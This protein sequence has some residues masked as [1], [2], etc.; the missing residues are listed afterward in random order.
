MDNLKEPKHCSLLLNF[1]LETFKLNKH[2]D[3]L[4]V[5][6]INGYCFQG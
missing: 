2:I 6:K 4:R 5:L 3:V 1:E